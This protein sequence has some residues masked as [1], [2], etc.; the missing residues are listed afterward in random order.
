M[1]QLRYRK[2]Y[3]IA[4]YISK[5]VGSPGWFAVLIKRSNFHAKANSGEKS[6][7]KAVF[8]RLYLTKRFSVFNFWTVLF[9]TKEGNAVG[10]QSTFWVL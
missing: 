7:L 8:S 2:A 3:C 9:K 1:Q 10:T 4:P 6:G 5:E